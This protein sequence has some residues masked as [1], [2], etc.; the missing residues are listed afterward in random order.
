MSAFWRFASP[1]TSCACASTNSVTTD[2]RRRAFSPDESSAVAVYRHELSVYYRRL[3]REEY[4]ML[5][6]LGRGRTLNDALLAAF[7]IG[8]KN[9]ADSAVA[10]QSWF[11][12]WAE[13]G[14]LT[15]PVGPP[16]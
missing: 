14:W 2:S 1:W 9:A 5:R 6:A 4:V 13:L 10:V 15:I 7:R 16:E 12:N 3:E 8:R 11:A